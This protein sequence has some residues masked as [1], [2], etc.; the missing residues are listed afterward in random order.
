MESV[1]FFILAKVE[2]FFELCKSLGT[3][4]AALVKEKK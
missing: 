3:L 1:V 4:F 2:L